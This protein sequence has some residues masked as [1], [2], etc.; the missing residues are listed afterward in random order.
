M[1]I[2]EW[3]ITASDSTIQ[4]A[5]RLQRTVSIDSTAPALRNKI[6]PM[7]KIPRF[8]ILAAVF[9]LVTIAAFGDTP[10][11]PDSPVVNQEL[12]VLAVEDEWIAAEVARD[13]ATLRRVI[14]DRF[15]LNSNSGRVSDKDSLI[16]SVLDLNMVGQTLSERSVLVD[17]DMAVVFGTTEFRFGT[18]DGG[19]TKSLSRYTSVYVKRDGHWRAIALHMAT[20]AD[21]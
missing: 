14:D 20:R 11:M 4:A 2:S 3:I 16:R 19:E 13:E 7:P 12:A 18:A 8:A 6:T 9:S 10:A 1:Q 21:K 15:V 5:V 17:G